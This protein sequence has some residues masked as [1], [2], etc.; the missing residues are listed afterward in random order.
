MEAQSYFEE[1]CG[2]IKNLSDKLMIRC[3]AALICPILLLHQSEW[4]VSLSFWRL[5]AS[6]L[7]SARTGYNIS[8]SKPRVER[9]EA[10][11]IVVMWI[12]W[13]I[14]LHIRP[15]LSQ[16][17]LVTSASDFSLLAHEG[18]RR[19]LG[20]ELHS[21]ELGSMAGLL[22]LL[23]QRPLGPLGWISKPQ[24]QQLGGHLFRAKN[25][26]QGERGHTVR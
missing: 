18:L 3:T 17:N 8:Y 20:T 19:P 1:P 24:G 21:V 16:P 12:N 5:L 23:R 22:S 15:S 25:G 14:T 10:Y 11:L 4:S 7:G 26:L 2:Q 13:N 6:F 9:L